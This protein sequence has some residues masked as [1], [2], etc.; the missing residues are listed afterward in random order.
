MKGVFD[1]QSGS[2][3]LIYQFCFG[4]YFR[5]RIMKFEGHYDFGGASGICNME[6]SLDTGRLAS[7]V[8]FRLRGPTFDRKVESIQ[9]FCGSFHLDSSS[10]PK[11]GP[12]SRNPTLQSSCV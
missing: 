11:V 10:R 8:K 4:G 12:L 9:L 2:I 3:G 7:N 5:F 1:K 6:K